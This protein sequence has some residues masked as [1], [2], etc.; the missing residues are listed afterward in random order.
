MIVEYVWHIEITDVAYS[1]VVAHF[2]ELLDP[3]TEG[4]E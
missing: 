2:H 4:P 1:S 3:N